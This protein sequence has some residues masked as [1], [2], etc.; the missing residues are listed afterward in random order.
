VHCAGTSGRDR[1]QELHDHRRRPHSPATRRAGVVASADCEQERRS[2]EVRRFGD[3]SRRRDA[4]SSVLTRIVG[5]VQGR[6]DPGRLHR[7]RSRAERRRA[8]FTVSIELV[9]K[10]R[11]ARK[12]GLFSPA[13][14]EVVAKAPLLAWRGVPRATY[15]NVQLFRGGHQILSV[16]PSRARLQLHD[17]W[18]HH[19][20]RMLLTRGRYVWFV[21]PGFGDLARAKYGSLLGRSTFC[22]K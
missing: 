15:Y 3:R 11:K 9:R 17:Q 20:R 19:G 22:V 13:A 7:D 10:A 1:D 12:V 21:W 5:A 8:S 16:W 4:R 18:T 2:R 6:H 14:G